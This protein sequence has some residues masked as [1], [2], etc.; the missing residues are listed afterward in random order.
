V[1]FEHV[2]PAAA[3]YALIGASDVFGV[4]KSTAGRLGIRDPGAAGDS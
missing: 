2:P 1:R 3:G 4:L